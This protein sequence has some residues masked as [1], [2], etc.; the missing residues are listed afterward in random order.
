MQDN[1]KTNPNILSGDKK[2]QQI[3]TDQ[4]INEYRNESIKINKRPT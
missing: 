1:S 4:K 2:R 3:K